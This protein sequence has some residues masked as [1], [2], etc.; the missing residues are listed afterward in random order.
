MEAA[1]GLLIANRRTDNGGNLRDPLLCP[2]E[3]PAD[4][5]GLSLYAKRLDRG[6][7][8]WL[9]TLDCAT[10]IRVRTITEPRLNCFNWMENRSTVIAVRHGIRR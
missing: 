2:R 10:A 1:G 4:G 3:K 6:R 5:V 9:A 7:F 8:F